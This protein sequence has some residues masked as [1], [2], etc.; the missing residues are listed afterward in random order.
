[1]CSAGG[2][3]YL[4]IPTHQEEEEDDDDDDDD[5]DYNVESD[6]S[7]NFLEDLD[8]ELEDYDGDEII[9][10]AVSRMDQYNLFIGRGEIHPARSMHDGPLA[11]HQTFNSKEHL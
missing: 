10:H 1:L 5:D 3:N 8:V 7:E 6:D 2:S 4:S 11:E 9:D